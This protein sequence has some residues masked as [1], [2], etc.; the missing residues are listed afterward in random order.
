MFSAFI[1]FCLVFL[2]FALSG[3]GQMVLEARGPRFFTLNLI[4]L[5]CVFAAP[6]WFLEIY[7]GSTLNTLLV[8]SVFAVIVVL[9]TFIFLRY[10]PVVFGLLPIVFLFITIIC[11]IAW[12]L[13]AFETPNSLSYGS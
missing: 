11:F 3:G 1:V 5:G 12:L 6:F 7:L 2:F 4:Y 8:F 13:G 9:G 10:A